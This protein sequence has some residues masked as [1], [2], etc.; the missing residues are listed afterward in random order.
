[1]ESTT[2]RLEDLDQLLDV[3]YEHTEGSRQL[4]ALEILARK[5]RTK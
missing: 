1:M 4:A 3:L 2:S 5:E